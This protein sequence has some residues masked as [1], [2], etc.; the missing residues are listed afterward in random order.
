MRITRQKDIFANANRHYS[1]RKLSVGL[2]SV[3]IGLS[4]ANAT[5]IQTVKADSLNKVPVYLRGNENTVQNEMQQFSSVQNSVAEQPQKDLHDDLSKQ[6]TSMQPNDHAEV[7]ENK[8]ADQSNNKLTNNTS[9]DSKEDLGQ[10]K[11]APDGTKQTSTIKSD[12]EKSIVGSSST[13]QTNNQLNDHAED[14]SQ[15]QNEQKLDITKNSKKLAKKVLATNLIEINNKLI[16]SYT[17]QG[18][19]PSVVKT[20]PKS[21]LASDNFDYSGTTTIQWNPKMTKGI[22][23][24]IVSNIHVNPS[25][26]SYEGAYSNSNIDGVVAIASTTLTG[27]NYIIDPKTGKQTRIAKMNRVFYDLKHAHTSNPLPLQVTI[28]TTPSSI[29]WNAYIYGGAD[30]LSEYIKYFDDKNNKINIPLAYDTQII[31]SL[32]GNSQNNERVSGVNGSVVYPYNE[33]AMFLNNDSNTNTVAG[34]HKTDS[35]QAI[36]I[37]GLTNGLTFSTTTNWGG[38]Q[39]TMGLATPSQ[40]QNLP[41]SEIDTRGISRN[42]H[43]VDEDGNQIQPTLTQTASWVSV[44]DK[45]GNIKTIGNQPNIAEYNIPH[46]LT[47]NGKTYLIDAFTDGN[48]TKLASW[49]PANTDKNQDVYLVYKDLDVSVKYV[50]AV[51]GQTVKN[52]NFV[53]DP[54]QTVTYNYSV[55]DGYVLEAPAKTSTSYTFSDDKGDTPT[56]TINL[57]KAIKRHY[58]VIENLPDGTQKIILDFNL[59]LPQRKNGTYGIPDFL[60]DGRSANGSDQDGNAEYIVMNKYFGGIPVI[61]SSNNVRINPDVSQPTV[62][63]SNILF[64]IDQ[65]KNTTPA[66][67][68]EHE[69]TINF[70]YYKNTPQFTWTIGDR[71]I[72]TDQNPSQDFVINYQHNTQKVTDPSQLQ[73]TGKRTITIKMPKGHGD[74]MTIIQ[75]VGYKRTGT[76]D[77]YTGKTT[78]TDW[79]FDADTSNVTVDGHLSTQYQAYVLKD[80]VVNY[81]PIKLPHINGYKAKLIQDKANLAM[82][83]VSFVALPQQNNQSNNVQSSQKTNQAEQKQPEPVQTAP[84]TKQTKAGYKPVLQTVRPNMLSFIF[85]PIAKPPVEVNLDTPEKFNANDATVSLLPTWHLVENNMPSYTYTLTNTV[86]SLNLPKIKDYRLYL[87]NKDSQDNSVAFTYLKDNNLKYLFKITLINNF[88]E[89]SVKNVDKDVIRVYKFNNLKDLD[90]F[91][92]KFVTKA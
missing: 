77:L 6:R 88:F 37:G 43:F 66:F 47:A 8:L 81:A 20:P 16:H 35:G 54:S 17:K 63:Y 21:L 60:E 33:N 72:T 84:A 29:P 4:F 11:V 44:K 41:Y 22:A 23:D 75:T 80:G 45:Q 91:L 83:M 53:S 5:K 78:Y 79:V 42:I 55:P 82:F 62:D 49:T 46:E 67:T 39:W 38:V 13:Q 69:A 56:I 71:G 76:L 1:L 7:Q 64:N 65:V 9:T 12:A 57:R 26:P 48:S 24:S 73:T 51:S 34:N 3:L 86:N 28:Y 92:V 2:A 15:T 36:A 10:N 89:F 32:D 87:V 30:Q 25:D 90:K 68:Q 58:R 61:S 40:M 31:G 70:A 14:N 27:N 59:T 85:M 18:S 74:Q 19:D 50:D 52:D